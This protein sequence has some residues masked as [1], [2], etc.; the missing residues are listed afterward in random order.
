[1]D[2]ARNPVQRILTLRPG[3]RVV[4]DVQQHAKVCAF[5]GERRGS[6]D[7]RKGG[8]GRTIWLYSLYIYTGAC[9]LSKQT[10]YAS[11]PVLSLSPFVHSYSRPSSF[12][13]TLRWRVDTPLC[14]KQ[15]SGRERMFGPCRWCALWCGIA[16]PILLRS[17]STRI[18]YVSF[19]TS[20]MHVC[21]WVI[22]CWGEGERRVEGGMHEIRLWKLRLVM[23]YFTLNSPISW[24]HRSTW[25]P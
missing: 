9:L 4:A 13:Q 21:V 17:L 2:Q 18:S 3:Q 8:K 16:L 1:M 7:W 12:V 23:Y 10:R 19:N 24:D 20:Y 5:G 25:L 14:Y 6:G 11:A 15:E 22:V